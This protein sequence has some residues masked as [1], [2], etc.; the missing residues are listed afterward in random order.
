MPYSYQPVKHTYLFP[1]FAGERTKE[2]LKR[3]MTIDVNDILSQNESRSI[4]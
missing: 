4:S 1:S 2:N 3:E